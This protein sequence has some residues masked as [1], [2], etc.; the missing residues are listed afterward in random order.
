MHAVTLEAG[1]GRGLDLAD[2]QTLT[3]GPALSV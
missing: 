3:S 1:R 2:W